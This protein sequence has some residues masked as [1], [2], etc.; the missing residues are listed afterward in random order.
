[1]KL[2]IN[3]NLILFISLFFSL[4]VGSKFYGFGI[5]YYSAYKIPNLKWGNWYDILGYRVSTFT[6]FDKNI[7]V[8][9]VSFLLSIS[10]GV[11]LKKFVKFKGIDSI[12]FFILIYV[13]G[14]HTWPIIMSTSNAM[15]QGI[16]MSLYFL[17]FSFLL[18]Q[19]HFKSLF[20]VF[21][22]I[23]AHKSGIILFIIYVNVFFVKFITNSIKTNKYIIIFYIVY[24]LLIYFFI[25]YLLIWNKHVDIVYSKIIEKDYRYHF[26]FI[27]FVYV[28][29]FS[30]KFKFLKNNTVT[31][32]LYLFSFGI[33]SVFFLGLNWE[34]ERFMMMMTLPYILIFSTLLNK[35]STYF[36][37][38]ISISS[39]LLLTIHN[40]M[41]DA[42]K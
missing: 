30:Y 21:I 17:S 13:M 27:S 42:L 7:G 33:F 22:S 28:L 38:F 14:L 18:E 9:L 20:F 12:L 8:Y 11:L 31:L 37:L 5:D 19:K 35:N 6:I 16:T 25:Y 23:F 36:F 40:G 41:Y 24:G 10:W 39:L 15:R 34:Y 26:I 32:F 1:M 29:L 4:F 2:K 3:Y